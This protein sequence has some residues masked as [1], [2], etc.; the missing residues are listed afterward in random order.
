MNNYRVQQT[1]AISFLS[2][3][4]RGSAK[5]IVTDPPYDIPNTKAG[6]NSN[7]AKTMQSY[8]DE[9]RLNSLDKCL[10]VA[11]CEY[12]SHIQ[13]GKIN[14]YIFCNKKQI[15]MYLNYFVGKLKCSFDIL[16]WYKTNT[17]PTFYNKYMSDKE[18]CL[19]FRKSGYCMPADHKDA[20]T[21]FTSPMNVKDKQSFQHPTVKPL[22]MIDRII[23]NSSQ[24]GDT[25]ID[26]F[27]GSGTTGVSAVKNGRL[28]MGC[29]INDQFVATS[30]ARLFDAQMEMNK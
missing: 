24:V 7:L 17:P 8:Q 27:M 23:R 13:D 1:D 21:L 22:E 25:V 9:L 20:C 19:Y 30:Q 11:W 29:D 10:G 28:F 26:P 15:P 2:S 3:L 14:C 12:I 6:G 18:Y 16:I 4:P 5:L